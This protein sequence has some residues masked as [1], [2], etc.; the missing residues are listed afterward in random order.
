ML[1]V[2]NGD[3]IRVYLFIHPYHADFL[4]ILTQAGYWAGFE[5]WKRKLTAL[6]AGKVSAGHRVELWDF[7]GYY[8]P[9]SELVPKAGLL[10]EMKWYWETSHYKPSLGDRVIDRMLNGSDDFGVLLTPGTVE[11][12]VLA[13]RSQQSWYRSVHASEVTRVRRLFNEILQTQLDVGPAR[14]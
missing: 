13:V 9:T 3:D 5:S 14:D 12:H 10:T 7:S 4:E 1:S 2:A 11:E 6:V 8:Q